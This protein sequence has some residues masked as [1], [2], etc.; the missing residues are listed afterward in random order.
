M[1]NLLPGSKMRASSPK[2]KSHDFNL[3]RQRVSSVAGQEFR[4][5]VIC[6][7]PNDMVCYWYLHLSATYLRLIQIIISYLFQLCTLFRH[8]HSKRFLLLC[9]ARFSSSEHGYRV[10][11]FCCRN[12][13]NFQQQHLILST[14][15]PGL[16]QCLHVSCCFVAYVRSNGLFVRSF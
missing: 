13:C 2:R 12:L 10:V 6:H 7:H 4:H 8:M 11:N 9:A 1:S 16:C 5:I 14:S 3:S 15:N